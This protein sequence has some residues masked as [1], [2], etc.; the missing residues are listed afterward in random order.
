MAEGGRQGPVVIA[1]GDGVAPR[2][3]GPVVIEDPA[4]LGAAGA[5]PGTAPPVPEADAAPPAAMQAVLA[6]GEPRSAVGRLVLGAA[7]GLAGMVAGVLAWD[8]AEGLL[9]RNLWLGRAAL[10]LMGVVGAGLLLLVLRELL[11]LARL[12]RIDR[13][14]AA[15]EAALRDG[16][17]GAAALVL[18]RLAALYAGRAELALPAATVARL[19]RDIV[20]ADALLAL[21]EREYLASL[22]RAAEAEIEAAARRVGTVTALVPIALA[23]M[24]AALAANVAMIRR[25]ATLYGGRAGTLGS[26]RLLRAVAAHLVATGAVAVGDDLIGTVLGGSALTRL[27]RR[28]GEGVINA[29]LTARVG[30]AAMEVCR[31]LPFRAAERPRVTGLVRRAL[32]G[33]V[34]RG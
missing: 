6:R 29:A 11:G 8:F 16:D 7:L 30:V 9:A 13:T 18:D 34:A 3:S 12:A 15:A 33:F 26:W 4:R 5:T 14:R 17:A 21:A 27:S 23:D 24:V 20:D 31:P 22:D 28:F 2:R 25:I 19:R 10:V 32:A 1:D